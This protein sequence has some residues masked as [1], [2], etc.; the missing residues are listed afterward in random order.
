MEPQPRKHGT[1]YKV[2]ETVPFVGKAGT[3]IMDHTQDAIAEHGFVIGSVKGMLVG[4]IISLLMITSIEAATAVFEVVREEIRLRWTYNMMASRREAADQRGI[5]NRKR[6]TIHLS[7]HSGT[8]SRPTEFYGVDQNTGAHI[9]DGLTSEGFLEHVRRYRRY[10]AALNAPETLPLGASVTPF[11][12]NYGRDVAAIDIPDKETCV[13]A[14]SEGNVIL[15]PLR[16]YK[17]SGLPMKG[18][19]RHEEE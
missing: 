18:D 8:I 11:F 13:I 17:T 16:A 2:V 5:E 9:V 7:D 3:L 14:E 19:V 1:F 12:L 4:I 15:I 10:A 6:N